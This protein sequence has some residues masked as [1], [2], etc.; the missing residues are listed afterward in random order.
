MLPNLSGVP[1]VE[2]LRLAESIIGRTKESRGSAMI[3]ALAYRD[4]EHW[5]MS[6]AV[7]NLIN[8]MQSTQLV[9]SGLSFYIQVQPIRWPPLPAAPS[10][11][12]RLATV[13]S[14]RVS[15][16]YNHT[17]SLQVGLQIS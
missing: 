14:Y 2:W 6:Y 11:I 13:M 10:Q 7:L 9:I 12:Y 8:N 1:G 17:S 5:M 4:V 15:V 16:E 3:W